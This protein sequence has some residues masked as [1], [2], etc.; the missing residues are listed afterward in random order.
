MNRNV[1]L[2]KIEGSEIWLSQLSIF[3]WNVTYRR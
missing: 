1:T 2:T 3:V